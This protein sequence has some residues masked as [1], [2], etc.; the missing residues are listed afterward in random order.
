VIGADCRFYSDFPDPFNTRLRKCIL[1]NNCN[2][3]E[4]FEDCPDCTTSANSQ[5]LYADKQANIPFR[6]PGGG[7]LRRHGHDLQPGTRERR[8]RP[9]G[10]GQRG[11]LR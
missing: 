8:Q 5:I 9:D 11:Q 7:L 4:E 3:I 6:R 2:V 1:F 10:P